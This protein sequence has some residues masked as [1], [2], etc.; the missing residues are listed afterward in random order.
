[1]AEE[2]VQLAAS[3]SAGFVVFPVDE[4]LPWGCWEGAGVESDGDAVV[5]TVTSGFS[6]GMSGTGT[7]AESV[8][9]LLLLLSPPD[10]APS[11]FGGDDGAAGS[12]FV[13][14]LLPASSEVSK[15]RTL[16]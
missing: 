13:V 14:L 6:S 10:S 2:Q 16:P 1:V 3:T 9:L 7:A 8:L 12:S 4:S 5:V 15:A 11:S